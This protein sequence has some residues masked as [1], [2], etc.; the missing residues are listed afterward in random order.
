MISNFETQLELAAIEL[1]KE[2]SLAWRKEPAWLALE[3]ITRSDLA[4]GT[5]RIEKLS[6][7]P[8]DSRCRASSNEAANSLVG[9]GKYASKEITWVKEN[10]I[11]YFLWMKEN[12]PKFA[13]KVKL[14]KL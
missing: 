13:V 3:G 8:W 12:V 14:L 9:F 4:N 6:F 1:Q 11:S 7:P 5:G 10:D 2:K